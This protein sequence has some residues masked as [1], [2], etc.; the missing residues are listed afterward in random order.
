L[1]Q[2]AAETNGTFTSRDAGNSRGGLLWPDP[3][4]TVAHPGLYLN[5]DSTFPS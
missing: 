2:R 3:K 1:E 4:E 5:K